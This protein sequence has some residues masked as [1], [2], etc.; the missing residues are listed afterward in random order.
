MYKDKVYVFNVGHFPSK[1]NIEVAL[2]KKHS[3]KPYI[4]TI[5]NVPQNVTDNVTNVSDNREEIDVD[6]HYKPQKLDI[7]K[8]SNFYV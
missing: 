6:A 8:M 4:P 2:Y 3:S 1:L 5:A 7:K